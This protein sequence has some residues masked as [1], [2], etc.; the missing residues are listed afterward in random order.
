MCEICEKEGDCCVNLVDNPDL[1]ESTLIAWLAENGYVIVDIK[2]LEQ[3][4]IKLE[5]S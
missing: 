1:S 3:Y 4:I 2:S 5:A